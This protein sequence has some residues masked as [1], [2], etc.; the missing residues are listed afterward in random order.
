MAHVL[1][2]KVL[3]RNKWRKTKGGPAVRGSPGKQMRSEVIRTFCMLSVIC[4]DLCQQDRLHTSCNINGGAFETQWPTWRLHTAHQ[5]S[6]ASKEDPN[7]G[8]IDQQLP[9]SGHRYLSHL[10]FLLSNVWSTA[11]VYDSSFKCLLLLE[12]EILMYHNY[13]SMAMIM[14]ML[15]VVC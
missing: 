14:I 8:T 2:Q 3:F 15:Y 11:S 6:E 12:C 5:P 4:A 13:N 9:C 1:V 10:E 7:H